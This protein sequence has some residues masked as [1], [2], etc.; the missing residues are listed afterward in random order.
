M[1]VAFYPVEETKLKEA[2]K[3]MTVLCDT[4]EN[5]MEHVTDWMDAKKIK[6]ERRKL[7][8]GDYSVELNLN[9]D[10]IPP[11]ISLEKHVVIERKHSI[12]EI[13]TNIGTD[14]DRFEKEFIRIKAAG[15]KCI[16]LLENFSWERVYLGPDTGG[17]RSKMP[18]DLIA[19]GINQFV[20]RYDLGLYTLN[21]NYHTG[22]LITSLLARHAY[23]YL[24][25]H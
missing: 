24:K 6:W 5:K 21:E 14:R 12:D 9:L 4:R 11:K 17:Y 16:L 13:A 10:G 25:A 19:T 1:R 2:I 23:N 20:S 15:A 7:D 18:P 8:F 22:R 3:N